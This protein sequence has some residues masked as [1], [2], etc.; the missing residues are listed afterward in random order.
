[1]IFILSTGIAHQEFVAG[2]MDA[3][4]PPEKAAR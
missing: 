3:F 4:H 2:V 1:M